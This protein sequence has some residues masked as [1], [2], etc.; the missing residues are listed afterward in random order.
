MFWFRF[1]WWILVSNRDLD[2][3]FLG[4]Y[5]FVEFVFGC[6]SWFITEILVMDL[7]FCFGGA[8]WFL[9]FGFDGV[10]CFWPRSW[11]VVWLWILV[12]NSVSGFVFS[13]QTLISF[14]M[15]LDLYVMVLSGMVLDWYV[16]GLIF[17]NHYYYCSIA[18]IIVRL[19]VFADY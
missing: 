6:W 12:S 16:S 15:F 19:F 8:S 7:G 14:A 13:F 17:A 18:S 1:R 9:D 2:F 5:W 3:S 10:L 11:L 4:I